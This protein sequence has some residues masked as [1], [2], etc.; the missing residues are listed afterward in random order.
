MPSKP[1]AGAGAVARWM[2]AVIAAGLV[3]GLPGER[4]GSWLP[5]GQVWGQT[6]PAPAA[7]P[8]GGKDLVPTPTMGGMQF[9]ADVLFFHQWRIQRNAVDGHYRL[10]DENNLR[11]AW[12]T[13][14]Q[15]QDVLAE[16]RKERRLPPMQG[17]GAVVLHGLGD[18]RG[19][20]GNLCEYLR[21]E[22]RYEVFNVSYPS[23]RSMIADHAEALDSIVRHLDGIEEISFVAFSMGNIVVRHYLADQLRG[24]D[25]GADPRIKR[26][27]MIGPPNQGSELAVRVGNGL[28]FQAVLGRPIRQLGREWVWEEGSLAT[29]SFEFAIIAGGL[30]DGRG[31]NPI[32]PGDNDGVVTVASTRLVGAKDFMLVPAIHTLLPGESRVFAPILRFLQQGC[33]VS[34]E[35]RRPIDKPD[36]SPVQA[37]KKEPGSAAET[38]FG[39]GAARKPL[40]R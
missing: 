20:M 11:Y 23:T 4:V 10:L 22:G 18:T 5:V 15:C 24:P 30:G 32:L 33:F 2:L 21:R 35:R 7:V 25:K 6:L 3:A 1:S 19:T 29:P 31:Y 28:V 16:I 39:E 37:A 13:L 27:V 9:W 12:G 34:P 17:R 8:S 38:P 26:M 14:A 40:Q 36:P